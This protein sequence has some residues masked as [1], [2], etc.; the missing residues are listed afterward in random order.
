MKTQYQFKQLRGIFVW[1][2]TSRPTRNSSGT[3]RPERDTYQYEIAY[4]LRYVHHRSVLLPL[5]RLT[6]RR[7]GSP[8][9]ISVKFCTEVRGWPAYTAVQS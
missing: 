7:R 2:H 5:L 6:P 8:G 4:S 3:E 1:C 9:T